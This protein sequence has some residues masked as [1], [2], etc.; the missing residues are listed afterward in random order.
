MKKVFL[1]ASAAIA[2]I[3]TAAAPAFADPP[4]GVNADAS[5]AS[6]AGISSIAGGSAATTA[7]LGNG[8]ALAGSSNITGVANGA[9][10]FATPNSVGG[11]SWALGGSESEAGSFSLGNAATETLAIGEFGAMQGFEALGFDGHFDD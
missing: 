2:M 8:I 10:A 5:L 6:V 3:C 4:P 1:A 7:S 9:S 11:Q